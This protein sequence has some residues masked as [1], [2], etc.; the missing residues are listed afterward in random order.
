MVCWYFGSWAIYRSGNGAFKI[1]NID[2]NKY[3]HLTYALIGLNENGTVNILD[4]W[5][6][7]D[8]GKL[9]KVI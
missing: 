6:D 1:D 9:N 2:V 7:I 8:L 5:A 3:T 4:P